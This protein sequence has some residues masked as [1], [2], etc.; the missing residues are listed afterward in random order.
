[1]IQLVDSINKC[2]EIFDLIDIYDFSVI[3]DNDMR[4]LLSNFKFDKYFNKSADSNSANLFS[5]SYFSM[6]SKNSQD[7]LLN[8]IRNRDRFI[9]IAFIIN[10]NYLIP[11]KMEFIPI[12]IDDER[13]Y[14]IR[15]SRYN[16][17]GLIFH[18]IKQHAIKLTNM[19]INID[20]T[21]S[22][23]LSSLTDYQLTICYLMV[24]NFS[25]EKIADIINQL[26]LKR[27]KNTTRSAIN[28]Q[29]ERIREILSMPSKESLV[30]CLLKLNISQKLPST[31][32]SNKLLIIMN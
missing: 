16:D 32:F 5:V 7:I 8:R 26:D 10:G 14:L 20:L 21:I 9:S 29:I 6:Q 2:N 3:M 1:M 25:N 28:V 27:T 30:E 23:K 19:K 4:V 12:V 17:C 18:G 24:Y 31:L 11:N 22:D 13:C 15:T